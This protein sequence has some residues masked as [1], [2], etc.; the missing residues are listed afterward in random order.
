MKPFRYRA[1]LM[2][3]F[4]HGIVAVI[5]N[6]AGQV[7][8]A[9]R[10]D[11]P[12][13]W[14]F[15]QG[16]VEDGESEAQAVHR[17]IA[18]ELGLFRCEILKTSAKRTHYKWPGHKPTPRGYERGNVGQ[19]QTWF[20]LR[21]RDGATPDLAQSDGCFRAWKWESPEKVLD[22]TIEWKRE[23]FKRGLE[24]LELIRA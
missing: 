10:S 14:Q 6:E 12:G 23:A 5:I 18:E 7:L 1:G 19:E 11:H 22:Q 2:E 4:R 15:P 9:E 17:E 8:M 16:G 24:M 3:K 13:S 21:I 20:L